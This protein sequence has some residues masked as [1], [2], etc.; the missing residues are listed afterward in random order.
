M[1]STPRSPPTRTK[2]VW[3]SLVGFTSHFGGPRFDK[4]VWSALRTGIK[5][6]MRVPIRKLT[7]EGAG[8]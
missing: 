2:G 7:A 4:A 6:A 3:E 1:S 5:K 8:A